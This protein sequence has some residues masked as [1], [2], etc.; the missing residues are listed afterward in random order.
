MQL[1]ISRRFPNRSNISMIIRIRG[2]TKRLVLLVV[3]YCL[4]IKAV[5]TRTLMYK[6]SLTFT[7]RKLAIGPKILIKL[8]PKFTCWSVLWFPPCLSFRVSSLI[9]QSGWH[10]MYSRRVSRLIGSGCCLLSC[11]IPLCSLNQIG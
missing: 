6:T 7:I 3:L 5:T 9:C 4:T 2:I 10:R 1:R 8:P 11:F